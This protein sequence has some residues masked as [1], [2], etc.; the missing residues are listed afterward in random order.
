[1]MQIVVKEIVL[2]D[3]LCLPELIYN[4]ISLSQAKRKE[5]WAVIDNHVSNSRR[6]IL[7]ILH[8]PSKDTK[9]IGLK[10]EDG[11][12]EAVVTACHGIANILT[13]KKRAQ[14]H[15]GLGHCG[16]ER[17]RESIQHGKELTSLELILMMIRIT[18]H[19][20]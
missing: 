3:V 4:L 6:G 17:L 13:C 15:E 2:N 1:M 14:W 8:K 7:M 11:L 5:F 12:Y 19:V 18:N 20:H 16:Q 9:M 10:T